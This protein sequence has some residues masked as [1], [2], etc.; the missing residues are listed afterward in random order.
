MHGERG[1]D[2]RKTANAPPCRA[3]SCL[4]DVK[5]TPFLRYLCPLL[6]ALLLLVPC[7]FGASG[8]KS[9]LLFAKDPATWSIVKGG[10]HGKLV[11]DEGSGDYSLDAFRLSP[12]SP[13]ALVRYLDAPSRGNVLARGTSDGEGRVVLQGRWHSWI[14]K[15]WVVAGEDVAGAHGGPASPR[16][17]R[18]GR[19]LF[20]E[21]PLGIPCACPDPEE[22]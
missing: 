18:P 4:P 17:W 8:K 6:A 5:V 11:Y 1:R 22:P 12:S 20:E 16:M 15:F 3:L 10:A 2:G 7:V 13:Y 19:Y 14:G 21:K 9:L